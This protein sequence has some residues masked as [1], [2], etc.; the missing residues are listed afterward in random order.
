MTTKS[1]IIKIG[2]FGVATQFLASSSNESVEKN[3]SQSFLAINDFNNSNNSSIDLLNNS[4]AGTPF[5]MA[6]EVIEMKRMGML[7]PACDIWSLGCTVLELFMGHPPY[8]NVNPF[9]ALYKIVQDP[10]PPFPQDIS[11]TFR[12]FLTACF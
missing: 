7:S 10:H 11:D 6:P 9:C 8:H 5:W 4:V 3:P 2:D 1:G 12:S